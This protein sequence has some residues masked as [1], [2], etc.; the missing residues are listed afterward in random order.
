MNSLIIWFVTDCPE[1]SENPPLLE[2]VTGDSWEVAPGSAF[3]ASGVKGGTGW[4]SRL[5]L[6]KRGLR[7]S[8]GQE[9][10]LPVSQPADERCP[11]G[12]GQARVHRLWLSLFKDENVRRYRNNG[13][14]TTT[15]MIRHILQSAGIR[16]GL[17]EPCL[18]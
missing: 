17:F 3:C 18:Q 6:W 15:W 12:Y 2:Q 1:L 13:K 10:P 4:I 7:S 14:S 5:P 16:T 9:I 11:P 8:D